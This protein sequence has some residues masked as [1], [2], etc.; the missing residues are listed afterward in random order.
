MLCS[1]NYRQ[2]WTIWHAAENWIQTLWKGGV[3]NSQTMFPAPV[4][5]L[6][7]LLTCETLSQGSFLLP[8][9]LLLPTPLS[10]LALKNKPRTLHTLS[11][12]VFPPGF[13]MAEAPGTRELWESC[14]VS[15]SFC[16]DVTCSEY[17]M[18]KVMYSRPK[19]IYLPKGKSD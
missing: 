6:S 5:I 9:P 3:C 11:Y 4:S 7:K 12:T 8:P 15:N 2:L 19:L 18:C 17:S 14:G 10:P 13:L 16:L 1:W